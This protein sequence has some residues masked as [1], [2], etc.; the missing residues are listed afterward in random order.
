MPMCPRLADGH[1]N[2]PRSAL[3]SHSKSKLGLQQK[4]KIEWIARPRHSGA[5]FM[6][7]LVECRSRTFLRPWRLNWHTIQSKEGG[8]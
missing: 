7:W 8:C 5:H 1:L 2:Q 6:S 3:L 4:K